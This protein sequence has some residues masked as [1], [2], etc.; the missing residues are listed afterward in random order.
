[1][2]IITRD[3]TTD[4]MNDVQLMQEAWLCSLTYTEY[5]ESAKQCNKLVHSADVYRL[6]CDAWDVQAREYHNSTKEQ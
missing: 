6:S 1:M 2:P 4:H 5:A 3:V